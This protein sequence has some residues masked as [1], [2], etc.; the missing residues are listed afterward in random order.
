MKGRSTA[1]SHHAGVERGGRWSSGFGFPGWGGAQQPV[2]ELGPR[3]RWAA[4]AAAARWRRPAARRRLAPPGEGAALLRARQH[5][6]G[7]WEARRG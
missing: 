1:D 7:G 4:H 6:A 2:R 3:R 5:R